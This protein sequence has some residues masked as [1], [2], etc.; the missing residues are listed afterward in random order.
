[1]IVLLLD[2]PNKIQGTQS[3]HVAVGYVRQSFTRHG[4]DVDS[5]ERQRA[6]IEAVAHLYG[7][8]LE[9]YEDAE[10]HKSGYTEKDC[11]GWH[12]AEARLSDPD[13]AA[14]IAN[15]LARVHRKGWRIGKLIDFLE[16]RNVR[17]IL[18]APGRQV[19]LS[20]PFGRIIVMFFAMC[21]E[22]YVLD[23]SQRQLDSIAHRR[24]QGQTIGLPCLGVIRNTDGYY[25]PTQEGAWLL[26]DG[27]HMPGEIGE[28]APE[29]GA[30]WRGYFDCAERLLN[31][32]AENRAGYDAIAN[33]MNEEGWAFRDRNGRP[34]PFNR[35][36]VR[37][38]VSQWPGYAGLN[39][40]GH[41]KAQPRRSVAEIDDMLQQAR[42]NVFP[43]AL[44]R[45][46]AL[47]RL[48]R[49]GRTRTTGAPKSAYPYALTGLLRCAH[50]EEQAIRLN[51]PALQSFING[52]AKKGQARYR[53][54]EGR[55]C[56]ARTRSL[57]REAVEEELEALLARFV[58]RPDALSVALD[59]AARADFA[60]NPAT[61]IDSE[62]Q[63]RR[64]VQRCQ[65][66]IKNAA[67][68]LDNGDI[69]QVEY[70]RRVNQSR[71]EMVRLEAAPVESAAA[72]LRLLDCV[73]SLANFAGIWE[74]ASP[75]RRQTVTRL[76][77]EEV[78]FD[79]D[80][81]R[82]TGYKLTQWAQCFLDVLPE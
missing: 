64:A 81:H 26:R 39:P 4:K 62:A 37:R 7:F 38:V 10:G 45:A 51:D 80:A 53:Y 50:C 68:R 2:E 19:D 57:P 24:K 14:L 56:P 22:W 79:L 74:M 20:T 59:L 70:E 36:D 48:A 58:L 44:L 17:L 15:D 32:Y 16:E 28:T 71:E 18:A 1:M 35:E 5:P 73:Q 60:P 11:P 46:V 69:D 42:R 8:D 25:V 66:R 41:A 12:R 67:Y 9:L 47:V 23:A 54:T 78:I 82:I 75:A 21:D 27:R 72:A 29:E 55:K 40:A 34:R 43:L 61:M 63:R 31:L 77:F 3:R 6:N 30:I 76:L 33:R 52:A 49:S 65:Q 13:V